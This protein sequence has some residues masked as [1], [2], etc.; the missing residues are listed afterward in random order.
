[1]SSVNTADLKA[2]LLKKGFRQDNRHHTYYWLYDGEKKT[3]VKTAISHGLKEYGDN[4]LSKV[5]KQLF[6]DTKTQLLELVACPLNQQG[7]LAI[8]VRKRVVI[9]E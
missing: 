2:A 1:M 4:L 9:R 7:Y 5:K 8:L 3:S 6:L